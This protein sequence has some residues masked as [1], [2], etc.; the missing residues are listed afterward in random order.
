VSLRGT[1]SRGTVVASVASA[2]V[3]RSSRP[4]ERVALYAVLPQR[5]WSPPQLLMSATMATATKVTAATTTYAS[6]GFEGH[7]Q[8]LRSLCCPTRDV[9][10][11]IF[12]PHHCKRHDYL[13]CH[14]HQLVQET[15]ALVAVSTI[16]ITIANPSLSTTTHPPLNLS[17]HP[18][19]PPLCFTLR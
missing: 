11:S 10:G 4:D 9:D 17:P 5:Q 6:T 2:A 13:L 16:L 12:A 8:G 15:E 3:S 7:I 14:R 1:T 18:H 19:P